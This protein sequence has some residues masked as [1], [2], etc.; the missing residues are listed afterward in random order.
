MCDGKKDC[1]NGRDEYACRFITIEQNKYRM[2]EAPKNPESDGPLK[3][4]VGFD[5]HDIDRVHE[6]KVSWHKNRQPPSTVHVFV[7]TFLKFCS[8]T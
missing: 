4:E 2:T 6:T 8:C 1:K 5:V 3:V 7:F